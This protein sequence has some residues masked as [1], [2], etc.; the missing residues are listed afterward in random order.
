LVCGRDAAIGDALLLAHLA[1]MLP[2]YSEVVGALETGSAR[3]FEFYREALRTLK[4]IREGRQGYLLFE[5]APS[6][7]LRLYLFWRFC[8]RLRLF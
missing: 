8:R 6:L 7:N 3:C 1:E 2:I 5:V 4:E